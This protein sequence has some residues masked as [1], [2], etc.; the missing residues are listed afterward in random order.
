M[1]NNQVP[2]NDIKLLKYPFNVRKVPGMYI[3][4]TEIS[5]VIL[6]E[7]IDNSL[8]EM[9]LPNDT[10][11]VKIEIHESGECIVGDNGRGIPDKIDEET[12]VSKLELAMANLHSGGKFG[13]GKAMSMGLHGLG[14]ACF[15]GWVPVTIKNEKGEFESVPIESLVGKSGI[16]TYSINKSGDYIETEILRTWKT[17]DTLNL[18][19]IWLENGEYFECTPDHRIL[20]SNGEYKEA[21]YLIEGDELMESR[22]IFK[23]SDV[24]NG[25]IHVKGPLVY[26]IFRNSDGKSYIGSTSNDIFLR[27]CKSNSLWRCHRDCISADSKT[28]LYKDIAILGL[29]SFSV[30]V[31]IIKPGVDRETL[32]GIESTYVKLFDSFNSGYNTSVNGLGFAKSNPN[33]YTIL[34][35]RSVEI[36]KMKG[37][38]LYDPNRKVQSLGGKLGGLIAS[39][40][41]KEYGIGLFNKEIQDMGRSPESRAKVIQ[42]QRNNGT[43][44][45]NYDNIYKTL[46]SREGKHI[47]S[48][49]K[50]LKEN[51]LDLTEANWELARWKVPGYTRHKPKYASAI[52]KY[53]AEINNLMKNYENN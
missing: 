45:F 6:R 41:Q 24:L 8:D 18:L 32:W 4:S 17:K 33:L 3:G 50:Y 48:I 22:L 14:S 39:R 20:L 27:F 26:R 44:F 9:M 49:I 53:S 2:E 13:K 21:Q 35:Y 42:T 29:E 19:R 28:E 23:L 15:P 52:R 47:V 5:D 16:K 43:G 7:I 11:T 1:E 51:N 38:G 40:I 31:L 25:E 37:T 34:A 30:E 12:G 10:N 36:Q 46:I